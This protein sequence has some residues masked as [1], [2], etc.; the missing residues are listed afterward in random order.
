MGKFLRSC[1]YSRKGMTFMAEYFYDSPTE[2]L[3]KEFKRNLSV[4]D[5]FGAH[6]LEVRRL[7]YG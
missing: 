5:T 6:G 1:H 7:C 3:G 2:M 4:T